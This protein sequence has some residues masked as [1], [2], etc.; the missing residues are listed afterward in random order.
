MIVRDTPRRRDV[1]LILKGSVVPRILPNIAAATLWALAVLLIDR[2]LI[3]MPHVSIAVMGVFGLSL[4]LFLGFRNNAAYD[5]WWEAR[6][7]WGKMV[8]D[9]RSLAQELRIFTGKGADE[10][11][12]LDHILAFHHLHRAQLRG[13]RVEEDVSRWVGAETAQALLRDGNPPDAALRAVADRLREMAEGGRIDG[14]GQRALA[15]RL[16]CFPAAQAGNERLMTT[17]LPFVYS[18]LVWRATYLYCGLL[19]FALL[20]SAGWFEPLVA[21]VV[22]YVFFGLAEVTHELEHPFRDQPNGIPLRA[23]CRVMEIAVCHALGRPAPPRLEPVDH[24]LD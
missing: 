22:A 7:L 21:A 9:L 24:V 5:R 13:D 6:K 8:A 19:P 23:M 2:Y 14:W 20:D 1:F 17:P 12:V 4:S 16:A 18:L 10:A 11:F 15:E 3:A